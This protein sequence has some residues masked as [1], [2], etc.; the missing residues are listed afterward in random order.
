MEK[1]MILTR[2]AGCV[3][4]VREHFA[5]RTLG[6]FGSVARDE[7]TSISDVDVLVGFE[8]K[9]DFDSFMGLKFYLE[10]LLGM[11]VDLVTENALRSQLRQ[12]IKQ[13]VIHVA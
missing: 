6:V 7:A 10:D 13:E 9:P 11:Q 5:V 4:E 8:S 3:A 2:L 12:A 1:Q